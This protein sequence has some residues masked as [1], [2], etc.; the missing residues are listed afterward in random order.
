M[1]RPV[2]RFFSLFFALFLVSFL[3]MPVFASGTEYVSKD[4][5]FN[6]IAGNGG[7][8]QKIVGYINSYPYTCTQSDDGYHHASSYLSERG[9]GYYWCICQHCGETFKAYAKDLSDAYDNY[10]SSL[11]ATG[12]NSNGHLIWQPQL[13]ACADRNGSSSSNNFHVAYY[14]GIYFRE[15]SLSAI[16][17][18]NVVNVLPNN[19]GFQYSYV[20]SYFD[21]RFYFCFNPVVPGS[22]RRIESTLYTFSCLD[23]SGISHSGDYN[24]S[25]ASVFSHFDLSE[26]LSV[27]KSIFNICPDIPRS[28]S[29]SSGTICLY[30]PVYEVIPDTVISGDTYNTTTRPGSLVGLYGDVNGEAFSNNSAGIVGETSGTY[31][32]PATGTTAPITNWSYDYSDRSYNVT[33]ESGDTVTVTYGDENITIQEGDTVYNIYYIVNGSG[34]ETLP[35][36]HDWQKND[37]TIPTCVRPGSVTYVCSKC[38]E[39]K[40]ES[41]PALG[42]NWQ[43]KQTVTT[44]YDDT[45]QLVQEGYTIFECSICHEQ[46]KS[47]DGTIPPGGSGTEPGGDEEGEGFLSWLFGKIGELLGTIGDGILNLLKTALEKIF[48]GLIDLVNSLFENLA[49]LVDLFGSVGEAFQVLWTWLPPEIIAILV[50]GVSIFVFV[51]LLKFFTK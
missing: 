43:V 34:T 47:S 42:H 48:G 10:V 50:A 32:N 31:Y 14:D 18:S 9:D 25:D 8:A 30:F 36:V 39:T 5:F 29:V 46:Y 35:C 4:N 16:S 12:Y 40:T 17:A 15:V 7:I 37:A 45:G 11:P 27:S 3:T 23:S 49:K 33:L 44:E 6:W 51:A 1:R 13:S 22:Y 21:S 38:Q 19:N 20:N 28:T 26:K 2:F 41:I 24:Y